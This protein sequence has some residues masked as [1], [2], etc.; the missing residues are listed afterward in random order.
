M[1]GGLSAYCKICERDK[2]GKYRYLNDGLVFVS[3][4][5]RQLKN[6]Y[7]MTLD[8]YNEMFS[9]QDGKCGICNSPA[10]DFKNGLLVDHCHETNKVREL[11]CINCNF[12]IGHARDGIDILM[13]C[14]KY[15]EKHK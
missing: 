7:G 11:L 10:E 14:I 1:K 5:G 9:N 3:P 8:D 12:I 15:L 6:K 13:M 2:A 4:R